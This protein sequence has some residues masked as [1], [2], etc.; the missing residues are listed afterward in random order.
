MDKVFGLYVILTEP[1][2]GYEK[3]AEAAVLENVRMLQLRMKKRP[4]GEVEKTARALRKITAGSQTL[5]IVNDFVAIAAAVDADG[6]HLGQEDDSLAR[7]R[8]AWPVPGKIFGFSTHG[9]EQERAARA[10]APDY[11]GVGPVYT[12]PTKEKPD[13]TLGLA[14]MGA[15]VRFSPLV[16]V[17]IGG[18]DA[19]NLPLV[20]AQGVKNFAVVRAVNRTDA[21][22]KAIGRLMQVWRQELE[23]NA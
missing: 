11:I 5:F 7:A 22:R 16:T 14:R 20:M 17:A 8:A 19:E 12:T 18:I 4:P 3:V 15:I 10:L 13:P 23:K 21:P 6:V 9:E 2:L 1:D